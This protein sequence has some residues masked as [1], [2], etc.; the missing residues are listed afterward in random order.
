MA[1]WSR[2]LPSC[3]FAI[4]AGGFLAN[5]SDIFLLVV[6]WPE[7]VTWPYSRCKGGWEMP[8]NTWDMWWTLLS[9]WHI[10]MAETLFSNY[11]HDSG[12]W[13]CRRQHKNP[14][15]EG[16]WLEAWRSFNLY[17]IRAWDISPWKQSVQGLGLVIRDGELTLLKWLPPF[18]AWS[19]S[20]IHPQHPLENCVRFTNKETSRRI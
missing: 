10:R 1:W 9:L 6:Y 20:F 14:L 12:T 2:S 18:E 3:S 4:S 5:R 8:V 13:P 19:T 7:G 11:G 16:W 17:S 15:S